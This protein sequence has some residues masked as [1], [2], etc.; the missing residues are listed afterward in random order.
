MWETHLSATGASPPRSQSVTCH[1]TAPRLNSSQTGWYSIYLPQGDGTW[2]A[3]LTGDWLYTEISC[4]QTVTQPSS[5]RARR[6]S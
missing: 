5:N 1:P 4:Q 6:S 2:K 3:E